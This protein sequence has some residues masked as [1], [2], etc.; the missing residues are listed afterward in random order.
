MSS[1][2]SLVAL[3]LVSRLTTFGLNSALVRLTS[4]EAFG[5]VAIQLDLLLNTVR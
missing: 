2:A 3:Q 1:A 5:T 4:A